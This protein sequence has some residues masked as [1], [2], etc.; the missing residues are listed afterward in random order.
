MMRRWQERRSRGA[1]V[2]IV[3]VQLLLRLLDM[4]MLL[5]MRILVWMLVLAGAIERRTTGKQEKTAK[6]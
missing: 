3:G 5:V 2:Q 6:G 4:L 1:I